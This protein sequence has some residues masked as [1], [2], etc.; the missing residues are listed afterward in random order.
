MKADELNI[1]E[2]DDLSVFMHEDL[3]KRLKDEQK[4]RTLMLCRGFIP[5]PDGSSLKFVPLYLFV[6]HTASVMRAVDTWGQLN[7][8]FPRI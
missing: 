7:F 2:G 4:E 3:W 1:S 5:A 8:R 6:A